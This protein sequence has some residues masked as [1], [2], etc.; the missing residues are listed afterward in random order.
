MWTF[1]FRV[2]SPWFSGKANR[3]ALQSK[4]FSFFRQMF[5]LAT[6][7]YIGQDIYRRMHLWPSENMLAELPGRAEEK[8]CFY[9]KSYIKSIYGILVKR[10]PFREKP[11]TLVTHQRLVF[12]EESEGFPFTLSPKMSPKWVRL[13]SWWK[14]RNKWFPSIF[15][16][17]FFDSL[18]VTIC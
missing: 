2:H 3:T 5:T 15:L 8:G 12:L 10:S 1:N 9:L 7:I 16:V 17:S 14:L 18:F 11:P 4:D 13:P 6:I